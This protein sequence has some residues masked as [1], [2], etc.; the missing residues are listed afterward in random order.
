LIL[1]HGLISRLKKQKACVVDFARNRIILDAWGTLFWPA[2]DLL[3]FSDLHFE[4]GSFLSQFANP[5]PRLDTQ[6]TLNNMQNVLTLYQPTCVICLGD[7][8]HDGNAIS[9]MDSCNIDELN[10]MVNSVLNWQWVLGNHDPEIPEQ[11]AGQS[12]I[13]LMVNNLLLV[14]EPEEKFKEM[15][16]ERP[17]EAQ[18]I[19]HF[20]PKMQVKKMG[21]TMSGKCF[22]VGKEMLLMPAFGHYTGGLSINHEVIKNTV[23]TPSLKYFLHG[24]KIFN[25]K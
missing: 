8:F 9:R 22:V 23:G 20:H 4:K 1:E 16:D 12:I 11:I 18:I 10:N 13:N 6:K 25:I 17:I 14:H 15:Q 5:L 3:V 21:H 2:Y 24:Q 19:G 7:S